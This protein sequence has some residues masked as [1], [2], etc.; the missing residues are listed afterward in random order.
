MDDAHGRTI[1][2]QLDVED[3]RSAQLLHSRWTRKRVL[4]F[5]GVM[6]LGALLMALLREWSLIAGGG[7]LGGALGGIVGAET[8]RRFVLPSRSRR[9]FA[10]QKNLQRPVTIDW[11]SEELRWNS[12]G[13]SGR[14]CWI[15]FVKWRRNDRVL[16]LYHSDVLFQL[17]PMRAFASQEQW[18]SFEAELARIK[19]A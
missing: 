7:L 12:A 11:D 2:V 14:T 3:Y 13:G 19:S 18:S 8:V 17:L 4:V 6:L 16:L 15:D 1:H 9:V 10:Q 5:L